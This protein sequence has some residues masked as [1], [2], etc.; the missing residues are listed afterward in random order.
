MTFHSLADLKGRALVLCYL[1]WYHYH[2][3]QKLS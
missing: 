1:V 2:S 3:N